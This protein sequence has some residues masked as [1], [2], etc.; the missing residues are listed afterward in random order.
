MADFGP[1]RIIFV[2]W[3]PR[4]GTTVAHALICTSARVNAYHPEISFFR[5]LL[6]AW[7][8]GKA[9]WTQHTSAFFPDREAFRLHMRQTTELSLG[10]IWRA[11]ERPPILCVKDPHLTPWFRD[12]HELHPDEAWFVT[13]VRDPLAVV[14]SRQA[15]HEKANP[16][17]PFTAADAA[18]VVREYLAYYRSV[19]DADF[20]GRSLV[21]RYEDLGSAEVQDRLAVFAGVDDLDPAAMWRGPGDQPPDP[22]AT[23]AVAADAWGSPKYH[24]PLDLDSRLPPLAPELAEAVRATCQPVMARFG[25]S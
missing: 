20:G 18:S 8:Y 11:L 14:R 24:G 6:P 5:G 16:E 17:R 19:L 25:Y 22:Q 15:V 12:L 23:A 7:R 1:D 4:S 13:V 10:A 9:A 3:A 2:G 21:F